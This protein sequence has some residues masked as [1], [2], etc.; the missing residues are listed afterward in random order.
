MLIIL[1]LLPLLSFC[2]A[3]D[4]WIH[5]QNRQFI[6]DR[7]QYWGTGHDAHEDLA[8]FK[9]K[10]MAIKSIGEECGGYYSK[11]IV[12]RRLK[13]LKEASGFRVYV[14]AD[15]PY[16]SCNYSKTPMAKSNNDLENPK[17]VEAQKLYDSL[18]LAQYNKKPTQ[19]VIEH[20][21]KLT[22]QNDQKLN[23]LDKR[24]SDLEARPPTTINQTVIQHN[25]N[26]QMPP[27]ETSYKE[28]MDDYG[29]LLDD[30]HREALNNE[31]MHKGNLAFGKARDLYNKAERKKWSCQKYKK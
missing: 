20:I 17:I 25:T 19:E 23:A 5:Q 16:V 11:D 9:A 3:D 28:C 31:G 30:A 27:S 24:L 8:I 15:I 21:K 29:D 7:I 1:I 10:G 14:H 6:E 2:W 22:K 13:I 4:A 12:I 26:Y 18:L